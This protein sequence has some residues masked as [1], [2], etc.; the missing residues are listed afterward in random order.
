MS[1]HDPLA[2]GRPVQYGVRRYMPSWRW[3]AEAMWWV[4]HSFGR[5]HADAQRRLELVDA[6]LGRLRGEEAVYRALIWSEG[7]FEVEFRL[8]SNEDVIPTTTQGLLMEGMRRLSRK[9]G[10]QLDAAQTICPL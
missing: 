5:A 1:V 8:I 6:E 10:D 2:G 7:S 3:L 9:T 4:E